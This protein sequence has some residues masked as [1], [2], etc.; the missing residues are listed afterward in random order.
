MNAASATSGVILGRG[1]GP[2]YGLMQTPRRG[3]AG[4]AG[5][6]DMTGEASDPARSNS[7]H[8]E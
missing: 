7:L 6:H 8:R 1:R 3:R 2:F 5:G 4:A